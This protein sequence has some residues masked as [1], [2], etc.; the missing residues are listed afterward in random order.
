MFKRLD[1]SKF[2]IGLL[3]RLSDLFAVRRGLPVVMGIILLLIGVVFQ[4][5]NVFSPSEIVELLGVIFN[6]LGVLTAIIGFLLVAPLG[7]R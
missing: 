3:T 2:L 1:R 7:G 6:S 5:V 4:V